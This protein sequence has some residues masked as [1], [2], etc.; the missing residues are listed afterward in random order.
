MMK[1][2]K[3]SY[4]GV[5]KIFRYYWKS[6]GGVSA[7][8]LSPYLHLAIL[9]L[10]LSYYQWTHRDWWDLSLAILP[11]L[12]GFSLG[13]FAIF[14]G[15]GDEVFRSIL[16]TKDTNSKSS[17]YVVVSATF[18]HFIIVQAL[19]IMFA[20]IAKSLAFYPFWMTQEIFCYFKY[21]TPIFWGVG[22]LLLLYSITSMIAVVMAIFRCSK[23]YET[24]IEKDNNQQNDL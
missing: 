13:G 5:F 11:N 24:F 8:V 21:I 7:L 1:P 23:W 17:T 10:P 18:V 16:A 12:L 4:I 15:L 9:L 2:L 3:D 14:L 20:L 22:Y 19:A 6:Y